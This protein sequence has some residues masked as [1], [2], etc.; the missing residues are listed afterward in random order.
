M[1][2]EVCYVLNQSRSG[3]PPISIDAIKCVLKV[4]L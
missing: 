3:R 4:V 1:P 2:L